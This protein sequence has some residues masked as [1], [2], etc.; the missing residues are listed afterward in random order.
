MKIKVLFHI[1][2]MKQWDLLLHNVSNLLRAYCPAGPAETQA[3]PATDRLSLPEPEQAEL[4]I[5]VLAN[6]A[7]VEGYLLD[8]VEADGSLMT[9]LA[10]QQVCFVACAH[11][12]SGLKIAQRQLRPFVTVVPSGVR[13]LVERQ[14]KG[15]AYIKP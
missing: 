14:S 3:A 6:A 10:R 1:D 9:E 8:A 15:Y 4:Q 7:A 12:L 2:D 5:E 13:E 11:A